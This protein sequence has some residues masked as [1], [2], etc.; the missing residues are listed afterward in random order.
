MFHGVQLDQVQEGIQSFLAMPTLEQYGPIIAL[1]T[2][3][4]EALT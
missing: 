2:Q 1:A 3:I 4:L